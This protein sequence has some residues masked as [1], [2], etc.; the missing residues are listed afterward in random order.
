MPNKNQINTQFARTSTTG[1]RDKPVGGN[2]QGIEP[3]A[4]ENG[5]LWV[6]IFGFNPPVPDPFPNTFY[7]SLI[8]ASPLGVIIHSGN[9]RLDILSGY[10]RSAAILPFWLH[11]FDSV[12]PPNL[13]DIPVSILP[14]QN[15]QLEFS[16]A[17]PKVFAAGI[18]IAPSSTELTFTAQA[19]PCTFMYEAVYSTV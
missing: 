12:A 14:L 18:I 10:V 13:G 16:K 1:T 9:S 4:D 7:N 19:A 3:L 6:N 15:N 5:R 17:Q 2:N 8:A 11:L